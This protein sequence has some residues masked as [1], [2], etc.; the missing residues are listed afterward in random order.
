MNYRWGLR[1]L[2]ARP[3]APRWSNY[4]THHRWSNDEVEEWM[5][6]KRTVNTLCGRTLLQYAESRND[7]SHCEICRRISDELLTGS[8]R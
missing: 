8:L 5:R 3:E 2:G 6:D 7:G 1:P 4:A